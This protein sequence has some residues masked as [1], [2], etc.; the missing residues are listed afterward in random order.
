MK[1]FLSLFA[2]IAACVAPASGQ[3]IYTWLNSPAD[4]NWNTTS[5]NWSG[6]SGVWVDAT[7]NSAVFGTS[8]NQSIT[9]SGTR[10]LN[11]L[12]ATAS[13]YVISGGTLDINR[14]GNSPADV[15]GAAI[16]FNAAGT[17]QI[18]SNV[19][20]SGANPSLRPGPNGTIIFNGTVTGPSGSLDVRTAGTIQVGGSFTATGNNPRFYEA[21]KLV[22]AN[23]GTFSIA[24][25]TLN[26]SDGG[27][28]VT[29]QTGGKISMTTGS[30]GV[31]AGTGAKSIV[32]A[33]GEIEV[34]GN[35]AN[36]SI[37]NNSGYAPTVQNAGG[38]IDIQTGSSSIT[39]GIA[40]ASGHSTGGLTK[41]G[42]GTLTLSGINTYTG[43]TTISAGT[44]KIGSGGATGSLASSNIVNNGEI[45]VDRS[46]T[47][48]LSANMSGTGDLTINSTG[49][50]TLSGNNTY[51]GGTTLNSGTLAIGHSNAL[52]NGTLTQSSGDSLL[53]IDTT[54]TVANAMSINNLSSLQSATLNGSI[55]VQN[56]AFDV[57]GG[58]TLTISGGITGT[59]GITKN[60]EGELEL[61]GSNSYSG[62]TTL[63]S[64][65]LVIGHA[66]ALGNGTL[67]QSSGDSLLRID[68]T[69]TV[70][71]AMSL[72]NVSAHQS[73]T[74]NGSITVNNAAFDVDSGDTLTLSG[75]VSGS[76]GVTKNGTGT[77]V[78]SGSNTYDAATTVN[79]GTLTAAAA[80]ATGNST[81]INVTGGSFLVTAANAVS[82]STNIDLDGGRMAMSG[83]FN[84]NVGLLTLS[85]DSIIDFAGFVGTLRFSGVDSWAP[86]ANLAIW[87]WSG[88]PRYGDPVNN[89]QTPS[90]LVFT[91]NATLT[92]NLANISFY[93]DSG[94][95]F[96]GSGFEQGFTG[97]GG[98]TEII[99][100]PE[101]ETYFYALALLAGLVVQYIRL[102]AKRKVCRLSLT[103][104]PRLN[105][106][107][108][109]VA[110]T[111]TADAHPLA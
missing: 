103:S 107:A 66:N 38:I 91:N 1:Q 68:T 13:G 17:L 34:T 43:T 98:G 79:S 76:G 14:T 65:T 21:S 10:T 70:A 11:R 99:A 50:L 37:F 104:D 55:T 52:G 32:F 53:R 86:S 4:A 94:T 18:D 89:Y 102:R 47:L 73:A 51:S 6:G 49:T 105:R 28:V 35:K 61:S 71:N 85:K 16:G 26:M 59:G 45:L 67:T 58:T 60:G 81:V 108:N 77:L 33:G 48:T 40:N 87:N 29:V 27:A 84:E 7:N 106:S 90:N 36:A 44:L 80:G 2:L 82:D 31:T 39:Q 19:T 5:T 96:I 92:N 24:N 74:L 111:M 12:Q 56:A 93:S 25:R 64:G 46:G 23:G 109:T 54:G 95:T 22:V 83:N 100:V 69:G 97:P 8:S 30:F 72:F 63:S 88:T 75:A 3:T 110:V 62:G 41:Q 42:A 15:T 20:F 9:V 78:L 57:N 101:T